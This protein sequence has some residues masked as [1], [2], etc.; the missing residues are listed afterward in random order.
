M[1]GE[2]QLLTFVV[3]SVVVLLGLGLRRLHGGIRRHNRFRT[4]PIKVMPY[5]PLALW[6]WPSSSKAGSINGYAIH[7]ADKN[8]LSWLEPN[9]IVPFSVI[10]STANIPNAH[11]QLWGWLRRLG[12]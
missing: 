11:L 6:G 2:H 7:S 4:R 8:V 5:L 1:N 9:G 3:A 12:E 10:N